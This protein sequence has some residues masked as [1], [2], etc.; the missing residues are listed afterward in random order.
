MCGHSSLTKTEKEIEER[1]NA[2]FYSEDLERY[3]PIPN[4]NIAPTHMHPVIT[5]DDQG[6]LKLF[7]WGLILFWAKDHRIGFKIIN[8]RLETVAEKNAY[9]NALKSR[10]CIVPFYGYYEW[11]K[12]T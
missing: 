3:N 7:K 1:F 4:F 12:T 11:Q 9:K 5:N 2:S 8:V 6:H 10:R